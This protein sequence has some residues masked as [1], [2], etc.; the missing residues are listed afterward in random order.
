VELSLSSLFGEA[1][2][3]C[4]VGGGFGFRGEDGEVRLIAG[5]KGRDEIF[6]GG[7]L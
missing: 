2:G 1:S 7:G 5:D 6:G 3:N 4:R